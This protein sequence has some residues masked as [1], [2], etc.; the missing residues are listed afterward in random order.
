MLHAVFLHLPRG[1]NRHPV[2]WIDVSKIRW[3]RTVASQ[4]PRDTR[5]RGDGAAIAASI[6]HCE[7]RQGQRSSA[8]VACTGAV[9]ISMSRASLT[10][11]GA[12]HCCRA[13]DG[14]GRSEADIIH[15]IGRVGNGIY[16]PAAVE[17]NQHHA[18][19]HPGV[20]AD[21]PIARIRSTVSKRRYGRVGTTRVTRPISSACSR[22]SAYQNKARGTAA[23]AFRV[24]SEI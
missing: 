15:C 16:V 24:S 8:G 2:L 21:G 18:E 17:E 11:Y 19:C 6:S 22:G 20:H 9:W 7:V 23:L 13:G 1:S 5:D 10:E 3:Q 14:V 4:C 12:N